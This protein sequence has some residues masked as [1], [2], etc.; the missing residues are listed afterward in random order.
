MKEKIIREA[1][2]SINSIQHACK[3][4]FITG[5]NT[6]KRVEITY[7]TSGLRATLRSGAFTLKRTEHDYCYICDT[8]I[9]S[10]DV[11]FHIV[12]RNKEWAIR[13]ILD[14]VEENEL[15]T[16]EIFDICYWKLIYRI[17]LD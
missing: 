7:G 5:E 3:T 16:L 17:K 9:Y 4:I 12:S 15:D 14:F 8:D 1:I 13:K 6:K 2:E 10:G 11:Y